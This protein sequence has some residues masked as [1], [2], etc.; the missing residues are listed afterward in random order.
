MPC[1]CVVWLAGIISSIY[2]SY[3]IHVIVMFNIYV[4]FIRWLNR[5]MKKYKISAHFGL[6]CSIYYI[7][8]FVFCCLFRAQSK[9]NDL[10]FNNSL[11]VFC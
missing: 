4:N 2:H 8:S 10:C 3:E 1:P 7:K 9:T 11:A 5:T 6:V